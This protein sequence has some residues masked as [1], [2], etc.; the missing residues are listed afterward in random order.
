MSPPRTRRPGFAGRACVW[1]DRRR[2]G[3]L[4]RASARAGHP[5]NGKTTTYSYDLLSRLLSRSY[6]ADTTENVTFTYTADGLRATA[7]DARGTTSYAYDNR[8]RLTSV[9]TPS[10]GQLTYAYDP[11][12]LRTS[13]TAVIASQ[14]YTTLTTYDAD[15]RISAVQD[16]LGGSYSV[17]YDAAGN[18]TQLAYPNTTSTAYSYDVNNRLTNLATVQ[19]VGESG[20]PVT[21]QSFAYTLD[22]EGKRTQLV[23]NTG[24]VR[25]YGYDG[26]DRL[27][28]ETVTGSLAYAKTFT[29]DPVGNR[30]SQVT[31]G[32]GAATTPYTYDTR[33]RMLTSD[34]STY[35]YDANGNALSKSG[36]AYY[37]VNEEN[38]LSQVQRTNGST[39]QHTY[40]A[41]GN[42]VK[43]M[44]PSPPAAATAC[45]GNSAS[46]VRKDTTTQGNWIGTYGADGDYINA[47][48]AQPPSYGT[49]TFTGTSNF[50]W[51]SS[52][53]DVQALEDQPP[54]TSRI[55]S[56]WYSGGTETF[57]VVTTDGNEHT[58][59][60][61]LLDWDG[62]RAETVT[63]ETP[64]G[65]VLSSAEAFSNF[66]GG[67]YAVY[68]I[69]GSVNFVVTLTAGA[70]AVVSGVFF[71]GAP[72]AATTTSSLVDT[73]GGLSQVVGETNASNALTALYVR[74]GDELLS[75]IRPNGTGWTQ[76]FIH[77]DGL[78]S[79]RTITDDSGNIVDTRGY[80]AFGTKNSEA[81]SEPLAYGFA[82][83][84]LDSTTHLAYHRARWMDSRVGRFAGMD[85]WKG[86]VRIPQTL[87]K[88]AYATNDPTDMSD[89]TGLDAERNRLLECHVPLHFRHLQQRERLHTAVL[90]LTYNRLR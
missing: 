46:F 30:E 44:E 55:A 5:F 41:D 21:V 18:R 40:D 33:D 19:S 63:A 70:N 24:T 37:T 78:G 65:T 87:Q 38:R 2:A 66:T 36:E 88:Y 58:I 62:G 50:T 83:E 12:G 67:Q 85:A 42:R 32:S 72:G 47:L 73:G 28:S 68:T 39:I 14:S 74:A 75:V 56:T 25:Q 89:P 45:S 71:G 26:I 4:R 80:E 53:T 77:K 90:R 79:V 60:L 69:C 35:T 3:A 76:H 16:P 84:P 27:T 9:T 10:E 59:A 23:E 57:S 1:G 81:G 82:G 43:T 64:T 29:Y 52:T 54:G 13:V 20:A 7:L 8:R 17:A 61:Y 15:G 11:R 22:A 34:G 51:A 6:P 86:S 49:V 48:T 31:T